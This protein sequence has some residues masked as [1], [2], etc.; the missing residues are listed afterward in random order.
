MKD[1]LKLSTTNPHISSHSTIQS[2]VRATRLS[3]IKQ[4]ALPYEISD[5]LRK[6]K[7]NDEKYWFN[8]TGAAAYCLHKTADSKTDW[9]SVLSENRR[10]QN[11]MMP[12]G[13]MPKPSRGNVERLGFLRHYKFGK[14]N[15]YTKS[16]LDKWLEGIPPLH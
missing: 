14:K 6:S 9:H 4:I 10:D 1:S 5:K 3:M 12:V 8:T 16:D 7:K 11:E 2:L 13:G 15:Y